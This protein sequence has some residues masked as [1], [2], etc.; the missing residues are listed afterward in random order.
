MSAIAY[1]RISLARAKELAGDVERAV[2]E[3]QSAAR[4]VGMSGPDLERFADA[5]EHDERAVARSVAG[6]S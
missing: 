4:D 1:C 2:A 3:W 5:F 6:L